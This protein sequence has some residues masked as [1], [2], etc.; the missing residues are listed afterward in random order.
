LIRA[1]EADGVRWVLNSDAV[2]VFQPPPAFWVLLCQY[3]ERH[4][5]Q[6]ALDLFTRVAEFLVEKKTWNQLILKCLYVRNFS[7]IQQ[8]FYTSKAHPKEVTEETL[9][10]LPAASADQSFIKEWAGQEFA[11]VALWDA[12]HCGLWTTPAFEWLLFNCSAK[13]LNGPALPCSYRAKLEP[14]EISHA[15]FNDLSSEGQRTPVRSLPP[16][17]SPPTFPPGPGWH[18]LDRYNAQL[19]ILE[20]YNK[21]RIRYSR[22][23]KSPLS[24]A[25]LS[26]NIPL[27]DALLLSP[28]VNVNSKDNLGRTPLMYAVGVNNR[29]I[30]ERLLNHRDID[31]NLRDDEDRTAIFYSAE[32]EDLDMVRLLVGT[33]KVDYSIRDK[34]GQ[35]VQDFAK[36]T[37]K[38]KEIVA[39]LSS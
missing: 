21:N 19:M 8:F 18:D 38:R 10:G 13:N 36:K 29:P 1:N 11:S 24:W 17:R 5:D 37:K 28:Q 16:L 30:V 7:F 6:N 33:Q 32:A 27:L 23:T 26:R 4:E 15:F 35:T 14:I 25:I 34:S 2:S 9:I 39:A 31:L 20:E 12:I 22:E 3:L